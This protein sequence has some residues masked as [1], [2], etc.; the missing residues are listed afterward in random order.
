MHAA[1][2]RVLMRKSVA[3]TVADA[4]SMLAFA[5]EQ[6]SERGVQLTPIRRSVL[7]L[8]CREQKDVSAYDLLTFYEKALGRRTT[9]NTI[10]RAL[11][12]LEEHGVVAHLSS[13]RTYIVRVF[14]ESAEPS[15][16]FVCGGCK[17]TTECKDP[18]VESAVS[19]KAKTIG[20]SSHLRKIE[21]Q[22]VCD[23]CV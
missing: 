14:R 18:H 13:T 6:L 3:T 16:F 19:A 10:Y 8:L 4:A 1:T 11:H 17:T 23:G 21:V 15:V 22:G 20:F 12:F 2:P 9:A 5:T 7:Q